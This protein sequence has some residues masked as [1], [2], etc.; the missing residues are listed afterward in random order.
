MLIKADVASEVAAEQDLR[1][2]LNLHRLKIE[3]FNNPA[4]TEVIFSLEK[5]VNSAAAE[6]FTDIFTICNF[7]DMLMNNISSLW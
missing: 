2:N 6:H 5:Q 3:E 1:Q 4:G 7:P